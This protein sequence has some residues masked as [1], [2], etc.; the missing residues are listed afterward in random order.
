M[1]VEAAGIEPV[2]VKSA[3]TTSTPHHTAKPLQNNTL[4]T[5]PTSTDSQNTTP[6]IQDDNILQ[7]PKCVP[8]VYQNITADLAK[9]VSAWD[10]LSEDAK[11]RIVEII[12][13]GA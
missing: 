10:E 7:Q 1:K 8:G 9:V 4:A 2:E 5:P 11:Q 13:R 12:E 6:S 3:N